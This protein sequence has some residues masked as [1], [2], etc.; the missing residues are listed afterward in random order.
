MPAHYE[1]HCKRTPWSYTT[2]TGR[3]FI[4]PMV[5]VVVFL[6]ILEKSSAP[7]LQVRLHPLEYNFVVHFEEVFVVVYGQAGTA[8]IAAAFFLLL[9]LFCTF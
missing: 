2:R 5:H 9:F 7:E 8:P 4:G 6:Q 1:L 3:N